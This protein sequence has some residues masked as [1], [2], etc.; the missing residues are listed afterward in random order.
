[1][2]YEKGREQ[3][4]EA[5]KKKKGKK[6]KG[7]KDEKK[8]RKEPQKSKTGLLSV[9]DIAKLAGTSTNT[10]LHWKYRDKSFPDPVDSPTSGDLYRRGTVVAW[11]NK[12]GR[13]K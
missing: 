7:Q 13:L 9:G 11:L 10:V 1:M 12:T 3:K 8:E 6:E 5:E 4:R 2:A